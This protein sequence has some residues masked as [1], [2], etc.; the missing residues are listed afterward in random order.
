MNLEKRLNYT[1]IQEP[2]EY[3]GFV[4]LTYFIHNNKIYIGKTTKRINQ[5]Y[6]GSGG[7]QFKEDKKKF[8]NQNLFRIILRF[9]K[10]RDELNKFE[11]FYCKFFK[12][13]DPNIGY[14]FFEG[15]CDFSIKNPSNSDDFKMKQSNFMIS[16]NPMKSEKSEEYKDRISKNTSGELNGFYG[17]SH[18]NETREKLS[19][20]FK[21]KKTFLEPWNKGLKLIDDERF[22]KRYSDMKIDNPVKRGDEHWTRK[23]KKL[24]E[25]NSNSLN[26]L[27]LDPAEKFG[28]AVDGLFGTWDFKLKRDESFSFK[29]LRFEDKLVEIIKLKNINM[30]VFERPSGIHSAAL[31]SHSK[32]IAVIEMYCTKNNIPY[33]GYSAT[34]IKK[35]AT[36]K[37]NA[38]KSMMIEA[39]REKFKYEGNDDNEVDA[40]WI[41]DLFIT[42]NKNIS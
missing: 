39:A 15:D 13:T 10:N 20:L 11:K 17:K 22:K 38:G 12:S 23:K 16:N 26:L 36:G 5:V 25:E 3:C 41:Y 32:F 19:K 35:H 37:G 27:A 30:V 28:W 34:E 2:D 33:K 29:L 9:C 18:S 40:L 42:D 6:F 7:K 14:N 1:N 8:G 4:Y 31:M 24:K 21:G